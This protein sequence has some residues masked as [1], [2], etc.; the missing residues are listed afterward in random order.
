MLLANPF[1]LQK[2][3]EIDPSDPEAEEKTKGVQMNF[4]INVQAIIELLKS[5]DKSKMISQL[6]GH[7]FFLQKHIFLFSCSKWV[8][9]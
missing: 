2:F 8:L 3:Y 9:I 5:E 7:V 4:E 6:K 1:E